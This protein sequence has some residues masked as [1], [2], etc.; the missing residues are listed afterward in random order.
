VPA[1]GNSGN[2]RRLFGIRR[3]RC[4]VAATPGTARDKRRGVNGCERLPLPYKQEGACS[5]HAPPIEEGPGNR[6]FLRPGTPW[7]LVSRARRQDAQLPGLLEGRLAARGRAADAEGRARLRGG[8]RPRR[9]AS[10]SS[11]PPRSRSPR[12]RT[13]GSRSPRASFAP[14]ERRNAGGRSTVGFSRR[15]DHGGSARSHLL[16]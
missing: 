10:G 15:G 5:S 2:N 8:A 11:S 6:A 9:R 14:A 7:D 3:V 4:T 1:S 12:S 13:S 16:I